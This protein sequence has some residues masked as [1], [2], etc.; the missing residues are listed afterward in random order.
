[1]ADRQHIRLVFDAHALTPQR[2][3]I[4][5]YSYQLLRALL[6]HE[7]ER[8]AVHVFVHDAI[9][10][11]QSV[12]ELTAVT[13]DV[14][15]GELYR[16]AHLF[17]LPRLLRHGNYDVVHCPDFFVPLRSPLPIVTTIHDLIPIVHPEFIRKSLKV[18]LLPLFR[19]WVR[20]A[21]KHSARVITVSEYSRQDILRHFS[22]DAARIDAIHH[23]PT[24]EVTGE[25]LSAQ[26]QARLHDGRYLLYVG[27][28]DPYKG[29]DLLLR[30]FA[31]CATDENTE[32]VQLAIAGR[33]DARY[34][35]SGRV[36][37]LGLSNRVVLLDYVPAAQLSALYAHALA[38]VFPSLYEGFGMPMLDAMQHGL[39]VI[40]SDRASLPEVAGGAALLVDPE[41]TDEFSR[42]LT[43][44]MKNSTL[45]LE[46][47]EKG[48]ERSRQFSWNQTAA[49]TVE[50]Y[51]RAIA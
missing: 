33:R 30:A 8:V 19:G 44:I 22:L 31:G 36:Q 26:L 39:P 35:I 6:Q 21:L 34:D 43:E 46:L 14:Q 9:H 1:M 10:R 18:R 2:S 49:L 11:V 12:D 3:G 47:K 7:Q 50:T 17:Q 4:G 25:A 24:V 20:H 41:Q 27:R 13:A 51:T 37:E 42:S 45:R 15:E 23:A 5:E 28:H 16:P 48:F 40:S 38:L 32:D 29:L